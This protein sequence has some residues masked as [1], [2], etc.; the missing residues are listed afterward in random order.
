MYCNINY[1]TLRLNCQCS[2][3]TCIHVYLAG[4]ISLH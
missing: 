4:Y 1:S 2:E 3:Y